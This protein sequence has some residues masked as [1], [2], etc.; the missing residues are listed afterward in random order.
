MFLYKNIT[1][2]TNIWKNLLLTRYTQI[3]IKAKPNKNWN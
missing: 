1:D 2:L 3:M